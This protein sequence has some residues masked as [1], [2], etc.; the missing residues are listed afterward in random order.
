MD[1]LSFRGEGDVDVIVPDF[2]IICEAVLVI[3][4]Y[5]VVEFFIVFEDEYIFVYFVLV[6]EFHCSCSI[7]VLDGQGKDLLAACLHD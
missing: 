5:V 7:R 2:D 4:L 1:F 3:V 6:V